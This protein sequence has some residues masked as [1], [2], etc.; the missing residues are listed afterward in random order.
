[1]EIIYTLTAY[2]PS[3]G[4]AQLHIH[5]LARMLRPRHR[6]RVVTQWDANR[7]DWLLGTTLHAPA[8]ARAYEIDGIAIQRITLA[9]EVRARLR[10]WVLGYFPLQQW[11]LPHIAEAL[12]VEIAPWAESAD[13]IHNCRIGREGISFASLR[14]ARQ[15]DVPFILTPVHHPRWNG[16][17]HRYYHRLYREADAVIALT[18]AERRALVMLGVE[19]SRV[20]VTGH[21]P[22]LAETYDG[23][24]FR[25][26][27]NLENAPLVLFL[28]QKYAYKGLHSLLD[29]AQLVWRQ[30]PE[31]YFA[32]IGPRTSY[33]RN[34]FARVKDRRIL[35]LDAVSLQEKTDALAACDVLCLPSSQESFGG[36]FTEA[37]SVGKPVVGCDIPAVR[38]VVDDGV[39]GYLAPQK[40]GPIAERLLYLL[41]RPDVRNQMGKSGHDKVISL[42]SWPRLAEKTEEIYR[43]VL[44]G[45]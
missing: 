44:H 16:W 12:A 33:S 22:V 1:M 6:V 39:N 38:A 24:R 23:A 7:T 15:R 35:E 11:A 37:W 31:T 43:V 13:L 14:V 41:D 18:E 5:Q 40:A 9:H 36:V 30:K 28:G 34:L 20:F 21:G 45:S 3:T 8:S 42:Y 4:G 26:Q 17:L 19:E 32:F 10:P 2:L 27:Y 25:S 29:A